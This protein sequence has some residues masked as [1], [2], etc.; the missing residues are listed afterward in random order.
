MIA[1]TTSNSIKVN[2]RRG[3]MVVPF[4]RRRNE[5]SLFGD[6]AMKPY[7]RRTGSAGR[8]L[9][10][11]LRSQETGWGIERARS[12]RDS[13]FAKDG[14]KI[15]LGPGGLPGHRHRPGQRNIGA[16]P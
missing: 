16:K 8:R 15:A 7:A 11:E 5:V 9:P 10:N 3:R 1:M 13:R 4:N 2:A 12:E 6:L 14:N